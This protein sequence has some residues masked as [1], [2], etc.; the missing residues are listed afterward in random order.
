MHTYQL[1]GLYFLVCHPVQRISGDNAQGEA[2]ECVSVY[3]YWEIIEEIS[4]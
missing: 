4:F 3:V 1:R 2:D